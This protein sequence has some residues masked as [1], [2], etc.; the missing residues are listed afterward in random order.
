MPRRLVRGIVLRVSSR[1]TKLPHSRRF[2]PEARSCGSSKDCRT[3]M[4]TRRDE[5]QIAQRVKRG[6]LGLRVPDGINLHGYF[7]P[8][9][10]C[11]RDLATGSVASRQYDASTHLRFYRLFSSSTNRFSTPSLATSFASSPSTKG[12]LA[13][14]EPY[15]K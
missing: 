8:Q 12:L 7:I 11:R 6:N 13:R 10:R 9:E 14:P 2:D 3:S 1:A 5:F 4:S 15:P